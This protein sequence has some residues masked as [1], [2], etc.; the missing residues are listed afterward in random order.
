MATNNVY[1]DI[2]MTMK[3]AHALDMNLY[4][5]LAKERN[6]ALNKYADTLPLSPRSKEIAKRPPLPLFRPPLQ[7]TAPPIE[8]APPLQFPPPPPSYGK[9]QKSLWSKSR[10]PLLPTLAESPL[11]SESEDIIPE[12]YFRSEFNTS[13]KT[14][15][16]T[17]VNTP[18]STPV[19]TPGSSFLEGIKTIW[20]AADNSSKQTESDTDAT[21]A[22]LIIPDKDTDTRTFL[23]SPR[24]TSPSDSPRHPAQSPQ[25]TVINNNWQQPSF[26][27]N[28][29]LR[30]LQPFTFAKPEATAQPRQLFNQPLIPTR[31]QTPRPTL[32]IQPIR[33]T[34]QLSNQSRIQTR[35]RKPRST[36]IPPLIKPNQLSNQSLIQPKPI[37]KTSRPL[38]RPKPPVKPLVKPTSQPI[39]YASPPPISDPLAGLKTYAS[40]PPISDPS[41]GLKTYVSS[42]PISDPSAGQRNSGAF[43]NVNTFPNVPT[44]N[45]LSA[46]GLPDDQT[47]DPASGVL[48]GE[49]LMV[50]PNLRNYMAKNFHDFQINLAVRMNKA[51]LSATNETRLVKKMLSSHEEE[52]KRATKEIRRQ[53]KKFVQEFGTTAASMMKTLV[54]ASENG[55]WCPFSVNRH[56]H[57]KSPAKGYC[58]HEGD[59]TLLESRFIAFEDST[60]IMDAVGSGPTQI[61]PTG[62]PPPLTDLFPNISKSLREWINWANQVQAKNVIGENMYQSAAEE[63]LLSLRK[64]YLQARLGI[65]GPD[66]QC[67]DCKL[68]ARGFCDE[69]WMENDALRTA[70]GYEP[71]ELQRLGASITS[72]LLVPF[73]DDS[74]K[75]RS[76]RHIRYNKQLR[77]FSTT[78]SLERFLRQSVFMKEPE[79]YYP[80]VADSVS[81]LVVIDKNKQK[82]KTRPEYQI[83]NA[84]P[85][86][87]GKRTKGL[88][89]DSEGLPSKKKRYD[90]YYLEKPEYLTCVPDMEEAGNFCPLYD[91]TRLI[92]TGK[93]FYLAASA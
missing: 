84:L 92:R 42:P 18:V 68:T 22:N 73:K 93:H 1:P 38:I 36:I 55:C 9:V 57:N 66:G 10:E 85:L 60:T 52:K 78:K 58:P 31:Q 51:G 64:N 88:E 49:F 72:A 21:Y 17:P 56:K 25:R 7:P 87:A 53:D 19:S 8:L 86:K 33:K 2:S 29:P 45:P 59:M 30:N 63:P 54:I 76:K 12:A 44:W 81:S 48:E 40:S 34:N 50:S 26:G 5:N 43:A 65:T 16:N 35:Q 69:C 83:I 4:R 61:N 3:H 32:N 11:L 37:I 89:L 23:Q 27:G 20:T 67:P 24:N 91:L 28:Q 46:I 77:R 14:P 90:K 41:A 80:A 82:A 71:T 6:N 74:K 79:V 70:I 39:T 75:K 13:V 62:A 15:V 47:Q